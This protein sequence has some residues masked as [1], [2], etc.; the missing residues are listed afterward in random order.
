MSTFNGIVREFPTI[1]ID[2]FRPHLDQPPPEALFLSHVHSDHLLGL[3]SVKMPFVYCSATTKQILLRLEK[4]PSRINFA[5][6]ILE[7]RKLHYRH[8]KTVLRTLP[9][10][11]AVQIQLN[12]KRTINVTLLDANHCPGAVMFLVEGDGKAILYTGD[13]RA[14]TWWVNSIVQNPFVLPYVCGLKTLDCIYL[15]TTFASHDEPYKDFPTKAEGLKEL[16]E[17]VSQCHPDTI[18]Y[19][20]AWTLGYEN[21]WIALSNFL[22]TRVHVDKYQLR[23]LRPVEDHGFNPY[24]E[25]AALTGSTVGNQQVSGCL[26]T[27]THVKIH[28]CEPGLPCHAE[29]SR[30]NNVKWITPII[31]R[32]KDGTEILEL[33]AGGGGG[34]LYQS[35]ELSLGD[36]ASLEQLG[37]LCL[38]LTDDE[39][40]KAKITAEVERGKRLR[41]F[42]IHIRGLP[43]PDSHDTPTVALKDLV[44]KLAKCDSWS[45]PSGLIKEHVGTHNKNNTIHF[46]YSR[47]SSYHELRHLVRV[48]RPHDICACTVDPET[49]TDEVSMEALF[50]DLCSSKYF[51]F[52]KMVRNAVEEKK[53]VAPSYSGKR[54][55]DW[56]AEAQ[57][58]ETQASHELDH[59]DAFETAQAE[60]DIEQKQN[61]VLH[62][63]GSTATDLLND[64]LDKIR[65][66]FLQINQGRTRIDLEDDRIDSLAT[67]DFESQTGSSSK[68]P[69]KQNEGI[70]LQVLPEAS[71]HQDNVLPTE[72]ETSTQG[73]FGDDQLENDQRSRA[74]MEAYMAAKRCLQDNDSSEWDDLPLRSVGRQGH[75]EKEFEL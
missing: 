37:A 35:S 69:R 22:Q 14:E 73:V 12:P 5:K 23:I 63:T 34:D 70:V 9:L 57:S 58:Q 47:H 20:R 52:D 3:E 10:N 61:L 50:G 40:V 44:A 27:D 31:S 33:G 64:T 74:R 48:F 25:G 8:L 39:Q 18:F 45:D 55:R 43:L 38:Q 59:E 26:T 71:T 42:H 13:V 46:P 68:L 28:S 32:L 21:V 29:L 66:A 41:D 19:F 7:A 51:F 60:A 62:N 54:K 65:A 36:S 30:L 72:L 2:Y 15:D 24:P 6:G 67:S 49:W 17:K 75:Q 1:R 53:I 11:T 4:Y 56:I 16:L